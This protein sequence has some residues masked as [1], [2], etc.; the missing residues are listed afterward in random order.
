M[1]NKI[2]L[3]VQEDGPHVDPEHGKN[4]DQE[5]GSNINL[6]DGKN[7]DQED[8]T[9]IDIEVA[10]N[11]EDARARK[12]NLQYTNSDSFRP[13]FNPPKGFRAQ[14]GRRSRGAKH[15]NLY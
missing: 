1:I 9:N 13:N 14:E 12:V 6:G 8:G 11:Q 2:K 15:L 4:I 10:P 7:I 3:N 5:K